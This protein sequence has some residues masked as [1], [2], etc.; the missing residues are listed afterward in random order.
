MELKIYSAEKFERGKWRYVILA[1]IMVIVIFVCVFY[2]NLTWIILM[3]LAL[4]S[5]IY[6]WLINLKETKLKITE[7]W[8]LLWNMLI[9]RMKLTWYVIEINKKT[10]EIKN[11]VLLSEKNHS[12]YTILDSKEN[13]EWF[14]IQL[15]NYLPM[16]WEYHQSTWD[17]LGRFLKL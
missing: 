1:F 4:W 7:N 3:F 5:Y 13:L 9:P 17:R 11:I 14:L 10:Q 15:N 16:A 2:K 12:I 8:L 6:L